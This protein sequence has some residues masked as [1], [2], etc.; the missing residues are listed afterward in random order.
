[1]NAG[2]G[3][4]GTTRGA[5]RSVLAEIKSVKEAITSRGRVSTEP[6]DRRERAGLVPAARIGRIW[7][8]RTIPGL[9]G[10]ERGRRS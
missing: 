8:Q 1:M 10:P 5:K 6:V 9:S 3:D 4:T 7:L 2:V